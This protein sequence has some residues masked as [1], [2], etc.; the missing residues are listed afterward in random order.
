MSQAFPTMTP[1]EEEALKEEARFKC[2]YD[3]H[4]LAKTVL[5]YNRITDHYH[6]EMAE[7]IDRPEYKFRLL[8]HPRGH[9]KSTLGTEAYAIQ[10]LLRDPQ[11]RILITNAKLDNSRKFMRT[12]ASHFN[13]NVKFCWLWRD[14]WINQYA[15]AYHRA[16]MGDKLNWVTRNT[17]DEFTLLRPHD[18]R[19]ASIT[20]GATNASLVSQHYSLIIADDLINRDYISTLDMVEKSILYF[21][22][23]LDLLD[24]GG[25]MILIGTR[26]AHMDLY[27]WLLE[28]FGHEAEISAPPGYLDQSILEKAASR[29]D[30]EKQWLVSIKPTSVEKPIFPEEFTPKV[31]EDLLQAKGSYEFGSQYLLNP[32]P[33]ESQ[34]FHEEWF[35]KL[36]VMPDPSSMTVCITVDPAKSLETHADRSAIVVFG[37]DK[38]N[39]MYLLDGVNEKLLPDELM[40]TVFSMAEE[41]T[42]RARFLL[43]VGIE[44]VSFQ[45]LFIYNLERMMME[46]NFFFGVEP[47]RRRKQSKE[48]RILR[49][50]PRLK[51][52]FYVPRTLVKESIGGREAPYDLVQRLIWELTRFPFA[53]R[54]DLADATADQLEIV[55]ARSL[56]GGPPGEAPVV[57]RDIY[58][59]PS[60]LEDRRRMKAIRERKL[61]QRIGVVR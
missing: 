45:E 39:N 32:T 56:P 52:G 60:I 29:P 5:G 40:N 21:K 31:L 4:Y 33:K 1:G 25:D 6:R 61:S 3:L 50:V 12:I 22:D 28:E 38:S 53:G 35:N 8:L 24:P 27:S 26:W 19:E 15:T 30:G 43:P 34:Q 37:Y 23:L 41:W 42:G 2:R 58:T 7:D 16:E 49:L 20:T 46:R 47:I 48:E 57:D 17:Q 13:A 44:A 10:R 51:Q 18:A 59:H 9:F 55:K 54:D 11:E 14:W 36:D